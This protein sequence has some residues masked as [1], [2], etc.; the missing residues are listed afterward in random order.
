MITAGQTHES[1]QA[2]ATLEAVRLPDGKGRPTCRP[3]NL[4]G[5]KGYSYPRVRAYLRRR[6]ILPVIPARKGQRANPRFDKKTCRRR[7]VIERCVG[8][9]K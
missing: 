5:D 3:R 8:W 4:A 9:L 2:A 7:N 1:K 6:G